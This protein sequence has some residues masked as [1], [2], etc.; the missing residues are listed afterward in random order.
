[1]TLQITILFGINRLRDNILMI[2]EQL[3]YALRLISGTTFDTGSPWRT[4]DAVQLGLI[5]LVAAASANHAL[6]GGNVVV[7]SGTARNCKP[8]DIKC[9]L[10]D[11]NAGA[12]LRRY[13]YLTF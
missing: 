7:G 2:L 3:T 4:L 6:V 12:V 10:F 13:D 1:M 8:I 9:T 11:E 5:G